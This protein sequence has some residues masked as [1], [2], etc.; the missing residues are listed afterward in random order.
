[1]TL[2]S[3]KPKALSSSETWITVS[4]NP[5]SSKSLCDLGHVSD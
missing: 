3:V 5:F 1:M 4:F 2:S